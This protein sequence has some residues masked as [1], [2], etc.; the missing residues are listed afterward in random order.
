MTS[1]SSNFLCES[2]G[3]KAERLLLPIDLEK[4]ST[5]VLPLANGFAKPF[6][7]RVTLLFVIDRQNR[8]PFSK[9]IDQKQAEQCLERMAEQLRSSI[10]VCV[11]VRSGI[12]HEAIIAEASEIAADLILLPV[13]KKPFWRRFVGTSPSATAQNVISAAVTRVFV[14]DIGHHFNCLRRWKADGQYRQW[15]A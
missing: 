5:D 6:D 12:P 13:F 15:A 2:F 3:I 14:V 11:R 1:P 10:D 4:C 8:R 7:S 9:E